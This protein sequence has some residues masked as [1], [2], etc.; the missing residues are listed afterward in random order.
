[1]ETMDQTESASARLVKSALLWMSLAIFFS[2]LAWSRPNVGNVG[3][4]ISQVEV[5]NL[6]RHIVNLQQNIDVRSGIAYGTRSA[7]RVEASH[8]A[9][10]YIATQFSLNPLLRVEV[11]KAGGVENVIATLKGK[12]SFSV[13]E[14]TFIIS[15]HYDSSASNEIDWNPILSSAPG[16]NDN[17]SGVA[18]MLEAARILS[19]AQHLNLNSIKFVAFGASEVGYLGSQIFS[20]ES[21]QR[22]DQIAAVINLDTT[23]GNFKRDQIDLIANSDS[24]WLGRSVSVINSWEKIGLKINEKIVPTPFA[25]DHKP[26]WDLEYSAVTLTESIFPNQD[27]DGYEANRYR[28]TYQDTFDKVNLNLIRKVCQLTVAVS[29]QLANLSDQSLNLSQTSLNINSIPSATYQPT[30]YISGYYISDFPVKITL[31]PGDI[32]MDFNRDSKSFSFPVSLKA[33]RNIFRI[34]LIGLYAT[35]SKVLVLTYIPPFQFESLVFPNPASEIATFHCE[36]TRTIERM[37]VFI[38]SV[39]GEFVRWLFGV[40]DKDY[41]YVW[42]TWWNLKNSQGDLVADGVYVCRVIV[43]DGKTK[44]SQVLKL[45]VER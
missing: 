31:Q 19:E 1:M 30:I 5:S 6:A 35:D 10:E 38:Y 42:R 25:G 16:A 36:A 29:F 12:N 28:H 11:V 4:W 43:D 22:K 45:A 13:K 8:N 44:L 24:E 7:H 40:A 14:R 9:A 27:S 39:S 34:N 37:E 41:S 18:A 2:D 21:F 32:E 26:F 3:N 20:F 33:G 17:A 23:G 15:A